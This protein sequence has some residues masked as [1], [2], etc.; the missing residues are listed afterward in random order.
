MKISSIAMAI[1]A[2]TSFSIMANAAE[3]SE[4]DEV[5]QELKEIKQ[6][7]ATD[8]ETKDA[9]IKVGGA[10]RFQYGIKDYDEDDKDRGGDFDFDVFRLDFNGTIGDV[11]LSAQYRW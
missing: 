3:L 9:S 10:V 8:K 7:L 1:I 5:K 2:T 4:L 11:T 6:Q